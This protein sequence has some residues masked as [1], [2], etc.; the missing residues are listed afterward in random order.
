MPEDFT[1][2]AATAA[3]RAVMP[4]PTLIPLTTVQAQLGGIGRSTLYVMVAEGHLQKVNI[5]RRAFITAAS[6]AAYLENLCTTDA[7]A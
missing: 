6:L 2:A 3:A 1:A 7:S 4:A 5:G